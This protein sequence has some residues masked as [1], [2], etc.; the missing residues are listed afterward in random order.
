MSA[1]KY[2]NAP[3]SVMDDESV[4]VPPWKDCYEALV[5]YGKKYGTC[6]VSLRIKENVMTLDSE[7]NETCVKVNIGRWLYE[8][9][10]A[11]K[12]GELGAEQIQ[13]LQ[14]LVDS[15]MLSWKKEVD[16]HDDVWNTRYEALVRYGEIFGTC[17]VPFHYEVQ[18]SRLLG[19]LPSAALHKSPEDA[20]LEVPIKLGMW[21]GNQRNS[22]RRGKR[23]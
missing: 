10:K 13:D 1:K 7:G 21:L 18:L 8:Q 19:P 5:L 12:K 4:P 9:R 22:K 2:S 15:G 6:N 17:N 23:M 3:L 11:F 16:S 14:R 20:Q